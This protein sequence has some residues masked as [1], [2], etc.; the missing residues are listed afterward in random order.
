MN[1]ARPMS[2]PVRVL[3]SR[4]PLNWITLAMAVVAVLL[5]IQAF[6]ARARSARPA[7]FADL[8]LEQARA[9]AAAGRRVLLVDYWASWCGP[10]RLM[11]DRTWSDASV[12]AWVAQHAV[13]VQIDVDRHG[14]LARAA[15]VSAI[16]LVVVEVD[17]QVIDRI[18]GFHEPSSLLSR[19]RQAT[20]R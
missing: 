18:A 8:T 7:V 2:Q 17:G 20:G 9:D 6:S 14:D 16:P 15:S 4:S 11:D 12:A 13:A 10:C 19:L 1:G 3:G 5:M